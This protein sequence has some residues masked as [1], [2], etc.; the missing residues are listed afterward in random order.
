MLKLFSS[1]PM[2]TVPHQTSCSLLDSRMTRL[3]S[4][5]RPVFSPDMATS[6][7][8]EVIALPAS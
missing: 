6:A 8:V 3:S 7:P 2:L 5:L 4:G 1:S